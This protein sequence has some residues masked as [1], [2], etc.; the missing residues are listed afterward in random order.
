MADTRNLVWYLN[1]HIHH[2]DPLGSPAQ[3]AERLL[4]DPDFVNAVEGLTA[5][6]ITDELVYGA[7]P[8]SWAAPALT[9]IVAEGV[10]LA[11]RELRRRGVAAW[12]AP[13]GVAALT[14][15]AIAFAHSGERA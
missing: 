1:T 12:A 11:V 4:S 5:K 3:I 15:L 6:L 13:I 2:T 10:R 14:L 9:P 7:L 8:W